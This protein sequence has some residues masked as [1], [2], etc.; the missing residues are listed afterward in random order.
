M[1]WAPTLRFLTSLG[2]T[3]TVGTVLSCLYAFG[4]EVGWRGYMVPRLVVAEVPSVVIAHGAWNVVIQHAFDRHT[5]GANATI[6][7]GDS[8]VLTA[9]TLWP[10]FALIRRRA[11]AGMAARTP[12]LV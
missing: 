7:T 10:A 6:W 4:E 11:W 2:S 12:A 5:H 8:E 1:A 3:L 9:A